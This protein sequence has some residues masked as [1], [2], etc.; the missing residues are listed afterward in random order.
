M[1]ARSMTCTCSRSNH[2]RSRKA[3]TITTSLS[4]QSREIRPSDHSHK[5][6]VRSSGSDGG[7]DAARVDKLFESGGDEADLADDPPRQ[8][9]CSDVDVVRH[10]GVPR[11][12]P[13][14]MV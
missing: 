3:V 8:R 10:Y 2:P 7:S 4:A 11:L 14:R 5:A 12:H 1:V 6:N 9:G 13:R